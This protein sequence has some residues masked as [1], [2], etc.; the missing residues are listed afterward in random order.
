[1]IWLLDTNA[2]IYLQ[3]GLIAEE[4]PDVEASISVIT[5]IELLSFPDLT[6]SQ[7]KILN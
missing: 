1:M 6:K 5:R 2:V 4:I 3:K 7:S